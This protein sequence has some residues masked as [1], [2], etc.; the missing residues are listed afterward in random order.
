MDFIETLGENQSVEQLTSTVCYYYNY[1]SD[2][3]KII[4]I[5]ELIIAS[6]QADH[7]YTC[8][9]YN[10]NLIIQSRHNCIYQNNGIIPKTFFM[11]SPIWI[12]RSIDLHI[13]CYICCVPFLFYIEGHAKEW[14]RNPVQNKRKELYSSY[15]F[16]SQTRKSKNT[17][18]Q[19]RH[20]IILND[21]EIF[22]QFR[23]LLRV[24]CNYT[25]C[26]AGVIKLQLE[27]EQK[28]ILV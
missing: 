8:I 20:S 7:L 16:Q 27:F 26:N 12:W 13:L 11:T 17:S 9:V 3:L 14:S 4:T 25:M 18:S 28:C 21:Y 15:Y 5:T 1:Y 22:P 6:V 10:N 2:Y 19:Y 23:S 24:S